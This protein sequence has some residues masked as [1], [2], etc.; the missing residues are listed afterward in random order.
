MPRQDLGILRLVVVLAV[1]LTGASCS[2]QRGALGGP[3]AAAER[4]SASRIR[5]C[6]DRRPGNH[7]GLIFRT[8]A[9]ASDSFVGVVMMDLTTRPA[10]TATVGI[11][12]Y[13]DAA[14]LD[15][16]ERRARQDHSDEVTRIRNAV[17]SYHVGDSPK[18]AL[19][20][21]WVDACLR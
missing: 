11:A 3:A 8:I 19:G 2:W 14:L 16:Y 13:D 10:R 17:V 12:I 18:L 15:A 5:A 7:H 1:V 21:S 9:P 20:E 4:F 6:L